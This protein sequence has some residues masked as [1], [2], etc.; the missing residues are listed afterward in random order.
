[1]ASCPDSPG[2][3]ERCSIYFG[4]SSH[5]INRTLLCPSL[6]QQWQLVVVV[7]VCSSPK[8][9][10]ISGTSI[11]AVLSNSTASNKT[12]RCFVLLLNKIWQTNVNSGNVRCEATCQLAGRSSFQRCHHQQNCVR[13]QRHNRPLASKC[14]QR[15]RYQELHIQLVAIGATLCNRQPGPLWPRCVAVQGIFSLNNS[16]ACSL[17]GSAARSARSSVRPVI[18][19]R[20]CSLRD[21]ILRLVC[22]TDGARQSGSSP[23]NTSAPGHSRRTSSSS[24][25]VDD[26]PRRRFSTMFFALLTSASTIWLTISLSR[27]CGQSAKHARKT[28]VLDKQVAVQMLPLERSHSA[29]MDTVNGCLPG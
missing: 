18:N 13:M 1:M 11:G 26:Q 4:E 25:Q 8:P 23:R 28:V 19:R 20:R 10:Q 16:T 12:L 2:N 27:W 5:E 3:W 6:L 7:M 9:Y 24:Q 15:G 17:N 22:C 29:P 14:W 21:L